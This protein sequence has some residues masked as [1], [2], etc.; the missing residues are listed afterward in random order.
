MQRDPLKLR[1]T[2][3]FVEIVRQDLEHQAL[4]IVRHE[5]VQHARWKMQNDHCQ[6][7]EQQTD[8]AHD[9]HYEGMADHRDDKKQKS[10][11]TNTKASTEAS[12]WHRTPR[13]KPQSRQITVLQKQR[14]HRG[15]KRNCGKDVPRHKEVRLGA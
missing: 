13:F 10:H 3:E 15:A 1:R 2:K 14:V 7:E 6:G 8:W 5:L 4:V 12:I 11:A 9:L